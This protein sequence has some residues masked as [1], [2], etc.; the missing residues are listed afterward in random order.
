MAARKDGQ[1]LRITFLRLPVDLREQV[2]R[3]AAE[4]FRPMA[5]EIEMRL[6]RSFTQHDVPA[7]HHAPMLQKRNPSPRRR[8]E[9][10]LA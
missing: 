5:A 1:S 9:P 8:Q 2:D 10:S 4:G 6:R 7:N 3:A